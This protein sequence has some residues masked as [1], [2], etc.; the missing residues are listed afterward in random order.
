MN[1]S[2]DNEKL[3]IELEGRIDSGNAAAVENEISEV[4]KGKEP[5]EL[6]LDAEK[7][8]YISS[9]GLRIILRLRKKHPQR[10]I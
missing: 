9:A 1:T 4:L 10:I 7:L 5:S 3:T 2:W 8:D 6:I